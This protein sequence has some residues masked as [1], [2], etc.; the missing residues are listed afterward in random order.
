MLRCYILPVFGDMELSDITNEA[1]IRFVNDLRTTGGV[2]KKGLSPAT[3]S[4][5]V[6]TLNALRLYAL[7]RDYTVTFTPEC[8]TVKQEKHD[9]RVF[10]LPEEREL[11]AY[12]RENMDLTALGILVCL[13]TGI[14]LGELCALTWDEINL[15]EGTMRVGKTMQ[16]LRVSGNAD[17][18]TEV[19]ILEPKTAHSVRTIP[20]PDVLKDSLSQYQALDA[21][22]LTGDKKRYIEPRVMQKRFKRILKDCGIADANFHT[23]RHTFATRCVELGFDIKSLSEILGHASVTITM[24]KYVHPTMELKAENMNRF[25]GLFEV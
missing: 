18:K 10:S 2:R 7:K 4:E 1:L 19:K 6:T 16:R 23:T 21:F 8:V 13:Y 12:L 22:L 14:R 11:V 5:V 24:N 25:S 20:L 3:V 17:H 15:T 9:I